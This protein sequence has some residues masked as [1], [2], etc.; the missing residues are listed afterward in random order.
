M[1]G[2]SHPP[3]HPPYLGRDEVRRLGRS[4]SILL[5]VAALSLGP[6]AV[7]IAA[8]GTTAHADQLAVAVAAH[9]R[10]D[11]ATAA[12]LLPPL[13]ERGYARAQTL[14]GFM[15]A[16]GEGV[17]QNFDAAAY[18]YRHAAEQGDPTGQSL[19]GLIYD[20][21]QGVPLDEVAAYKWLDLAAA[22]AGKREREYYVHLRDAVA[23]KMT[24]GQLAEAQRLAYEWTQQ[25][26]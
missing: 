3:Q 1:V 6:A 2:T 7:A 19:L 25:Q 24:T 14:L 10:A 8:D 5:T 18:W 15:Y 4:A 21:G 22:R 16:T 11:Y 26:R 23:G 9:G 12:R 17:P 13:A 20:K